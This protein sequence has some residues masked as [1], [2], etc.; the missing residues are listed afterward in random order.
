[1]GQGSGRHNWS[2]P[3][4]SGID[5]RARSNSKT[6]NMDNTKL[7]GPRAHFFEQGRIAASKYATLEEAAKADEERLTAYVLK[8]QTKRHHNQHLV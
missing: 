5:P 7:T 6:S 1:M 3:Q 8:V 4:A 2:Q